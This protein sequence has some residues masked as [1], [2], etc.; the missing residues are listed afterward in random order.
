[1]ESPA[2]V[3]RARGT[4]GPFNVGIGVSAREEVS[5]EDADSAIC[6]VCVLRC[7]VLMEVARL[8]VHRP[9]TSQARSQ[10]SWAVPRE[11]LG[12]CAE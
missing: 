1:M 12:A 11:V 4:P 10:R 2:H 7:C 3:V 9:Y 8:T 6:T 5:K